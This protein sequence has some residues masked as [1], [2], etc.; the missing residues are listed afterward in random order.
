MG[1]SQILIVVAIG[2]NFQL[3]II[4]VDIF[5][6][7]TFNPFLKDFI[8]LSISIWFIGK[9]QLRIMGANN[10]CYTHMDPKTFD[11]LETLRK[12][13]A[14]ILGSS[15]EYHTWSAGARYPNPIIKKSTFL[16]QLNYRVSKAILSKRYQT[17]LVN[18]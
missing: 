7:R 6:S 1:T 4:V 10:N 8:S 5:S 3:L 18:H 2:H 13:L 14:W 12:I 17:E 15:L 11:D 9:K 16:F